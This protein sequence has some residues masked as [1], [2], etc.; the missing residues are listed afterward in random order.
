MS[1]MEPATQVQ[2]LA[3]AVG[4]AGRGRGRAGP[5]DHAGQI[6]EL[7]AHVDDIDFAAA[8]PTSGGCGTT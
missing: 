6:A 4:G 1:A 7:R 3:A 5:A 2:H 8:G